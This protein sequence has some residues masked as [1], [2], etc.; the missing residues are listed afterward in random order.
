[1]SLIYLVRHGETD[2]SQED[3]AQGQTDVPLNDTG[4]NTARVL[5]DYI[6][7]NLDITK[8]FLSDLL[9][10]KQTCE[11]ILRKMSKPIEYQTVEALREISLGI[12]EGKPIQEL[13]VLRFAS[14]DYNSFVP[15]GGESFNQLIERVMKWFRLN[16][17]QLN[18][19]LIIS[20]RGPMS[21]LAD[22]SENEDE[23]DIKE[24][25]LKQG[26]IVVLKTFSL[27][28]FRIEKIIEV[29]EEL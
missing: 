5:G 17:T 16:Y 27:D 20:H 9:R 22:A 2:Y 12:F 4:F 7:K 3:I 13:D 19:S 10:C 18:N 15:E 8:I 11:P 28:S 1:M 24:E 23:F 26:N 29:G 21:V 14:G 25:V 6:S